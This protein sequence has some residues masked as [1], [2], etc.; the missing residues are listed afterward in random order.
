MR[1]MKYQV[2]LHNRPFIQPF[3][4]HS[5]E[6]FMFIHV[7]SWWTLLSHSCPFMSTLPSHS[8]PSHPIRSNPTVSF[9]PIP[10]H[11]K[12]FFILPEKCFRP[13]FFTSSAYLFYSKYV[14]KNSYSLLR[15][16]LNIIFKEEFNAISNFYLKN[17][18]WQ[19]TG[20]KFVF[21]QKKPIL[22]LK[23]TKTKRKLFKIVIAC[24]LAWIRP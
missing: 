9:V 15:P 11:W 8:Y 12:E 1:S 10:S 23:R 5:C 18:L 22:G 6:P 20:E 7:H 21:S 16:D 24:F 13:T 14:N 2:P 4:V 3:I 19:K 17:F